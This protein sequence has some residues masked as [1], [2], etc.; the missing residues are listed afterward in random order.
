MTITSPRLVLAVGASLG[1][2]GASGQAFL[3][4]SNSAQ[5]APLR[6]LL[7]FTLAVLVGT[8][9]S[10]TAKREALKAAG[11]VGFVAGFLNP[12]VG[13]GLLLRSPNLLGIHPFASIE[14]ALSFTR[15]ILTGAMISSWI[16]AGIAIL[17]ALP[18]SQTSIVESSDG[19][20]I[21]ELSEMLVFGKIRKGILHEEE[22]VSCGADCGG[23]EA[24]PPG[25]TRDRGDPEGRDQRADLLSMEETV[26][27]DGDGPGPAD[28]TTLGRE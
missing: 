28:E 6:G 17:I 14:S 2:L 24:G 4:H 10:P 13:L 5:T 11:L 8:F 1:C 21:F 7:T 9:A 27:R 23:A 25:C 19:P 22:A 15:S 26:C 20:G 3:M 16:I 18:I 12:S